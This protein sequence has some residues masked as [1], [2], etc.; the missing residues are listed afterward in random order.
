MT[1]KG[2]NIEAYM[3]LWIADYLAD[4]TRL[5]YAL[6]GAYLL[7]LMSY[8]RE[9]QPLSDNDD[10]LAAIIGAP[11]KKWRKDVRPRLERFFQIADGLWFHKRVEKELESAIA[12]RAKKTE[13]GQ[14]GAQTRW[15][16]V[17]KRIAGAMAEPSANAWQNDA[18]SPSP[19]IPEANASGAGAPRVADE[20]WRSGLRYL[21]AQ[22]VAEKQARSLIGKW[23]KAHGEAAVLDALIGAERQSVS[24]PVPWITSALSGKVPFGRVVPHPNAPKTW[25]DEFGRTWEIDP[26]TGESRVAMGAA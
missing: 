8:W 9:A 16:T 11:V 23:R 4:T 3:P 15:Q 5:T 21:T 2:K 24:D 1:R 14:K 22:G 25:Q 10:E 6:H 7:L 19:S 12:I 13:A 17:G 26:K 20:V 18:I